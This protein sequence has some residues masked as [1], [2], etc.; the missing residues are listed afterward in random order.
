MGSEEF[1]ISQVFE[2]FTQKGEVF[3]SVRWKLESYK[4]GEASIEP[5]C[6][7]VNSD[8]V[9]NKAL[10]DFLNTQN[11]VLVWKVRQIPG[12]TEQVEVSF[13]GYISFHKLPVGRLKT[14]SGTTWQ[15]VLGLQPD[16]TTAAAT[17]SGNYLSRDLWVYADPKIGI[18]WETVVTGCLG[19]PLGRF[20]NLFLSRCFQRTSTH[21]SIPTTTIQTTFDTFTRSD[22]PE[23][24]QE[25]FHR[26]LLVT[27]LIFGRITALSPIHT[28]PYLAYSCES[29]KVKAEVL[30]WLKGVGNGLFGDNDCIPKINGQNPVD[31]VVAIE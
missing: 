27:F 29:D 24:A 21:P 6:N 8:G 7:F 5:L 1:D 19:L 15:V 14:L 13:Y 2:L 31:D 10:M 4:A 16:S 9:M 26:F 22:D 18:R 12:D 25:R 28:H 11:Q 23:L 20:L 30:T 3:V 17:R